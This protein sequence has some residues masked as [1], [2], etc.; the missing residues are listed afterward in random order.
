MVRWL[1]HGAWAAPAAGWLLI[2]ANTGMVV[3]SAIAAAVLIATV[4]A[5]VNH[6]E[7]AAH[8]EPFGPFLRAVAVTII[9]LGLIITLMSA[10]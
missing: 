3:S 8:R 10:A 5:A 6:A 7:V 9:E 4:L 1:Q 2:A